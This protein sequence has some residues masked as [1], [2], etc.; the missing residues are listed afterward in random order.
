VE[1]DVALF[2]HG[3]QRLSAEVQIVWRADVD[4]E[5]LAAAVRGGNDG[6]AWTRLL[7]ELVETCPPSTL[8]AITVPLSAARGWLARVAMRH[9]EGTV[10]TSKE[11]TIPAVAD[12]EGEITD[13]LPRLETI[14][15]VLVWRGE[16]SE[17]ITS[18]AGLQPGDTLVV[19]A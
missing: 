14:A 10:R 1:P 11:S 15:P 3:P 19:P 8:E 13:E 18:P 9:S 16:E 7:V 6:R 5:W 4:V 17:V 2:L 12:V